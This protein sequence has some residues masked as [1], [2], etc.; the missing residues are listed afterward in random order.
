MKG[1]K[2][3]LF[4]IDNTVVQCAVSDLF[5][6][7]WNRFPWLM[8]PASVILHVKRGLITAH[9]LLFQQITK[10]QWWNPVLCSK[11]ATTL[12]CGPEARRSDMGAAFLW[13][14]R[15][16]EWAWWII[17]ISQ[18]LVLSKM[19]KCI[20]GGGIEERQHSFFFHAF[21]TDEWT[22]W[23]KR[24][25][26]AYRRGKHVRY[27]SLNCWSFKGERKMKCSGLILNPLHEGRL[28]TTKYTHQQAV[29]HL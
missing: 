10:D 28:T 17:E 1:A 26:W 20:K 13:S 19:Q 16:S 3:K 27:K 2:E 15:H 12:N 6:S 24:W 14:L 25:N 4:P 23:K 18:S 21:V 11:E 8:P 9:K 7:T 29:W 5:R 22:Y